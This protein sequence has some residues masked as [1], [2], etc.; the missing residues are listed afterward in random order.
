MLER[1]A[2]AIYGM[3]ELANLLTTEDGENIVIKRLQVIDMARGLLNSIAIDSEGES[4]DFKTI[5][6]AGVKDV[7]D[8]TCNML[9]A[10]TNIPQTILFGR[11]PAG[12]NSTGQSDL[13][14][15]YNYIERI[16]K[17]M[18]RGNLKTLLDII[19][20]V[21]LKAGKLDEEP[22]IKLTFNPLW[23]MSDSEQA[24]VN[25]QNAQTQFIK[26]QAAQIYVDMGALDPSEVR[27]G[28]AQEAEFEVEELLDDIDV[29]NENMWGGEGSP[30]PNEPLNPGADV[31]KNNRE[32]AEKPL[33][34]AGQPSR[35]NIT[36]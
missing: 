16:Q 5:P 27:K 30:N 17:L 22:A 12:Q 3:K 23:S 31:D 33:T 24:A 18:L 32:T 1:S 34:P 10:V 26:A 15:Y 2:Q 13:E 4:Y 19:S 21:G 6:M 36:E 29:E 7:I 14:N 25:Q 9:S 35:M 20:R 8:A 28:L 11:S